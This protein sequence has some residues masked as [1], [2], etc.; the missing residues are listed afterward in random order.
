MA[1]NN[2]IHP[3]GPVVRRGEFVFV[4]VPN[5]RIRNVAAKRRS[6][7]A[8]SAE[9]AGSEKGQ[10]APSG[11][12]GGSGRGGGTRD[13]VLHPLVLP[14]DRILTVRRSRELRASEEARPG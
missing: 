2:S 13:S 6:P 5:S 4:F 12:L 3:D 1:Y 8:V 7:A 11:R 9:P 10:P 14:R